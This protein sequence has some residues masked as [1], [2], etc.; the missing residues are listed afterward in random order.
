MKLNYLPG[1]IDQ[2]LHSFSSQKAPRE[3]KSFGS[4][5]FRW[6]IYNQPADSASVRV[7]LS[8]QFRI[9]SELSYVGK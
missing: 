7:E 9:R 3:L 2:N 8:K 4:Q 6:Q 5:S 1:I